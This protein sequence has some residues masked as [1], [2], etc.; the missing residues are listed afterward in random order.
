MDETIVNK[1]NQL[2]RN[3]ITEALL[4]L[5]K[6][7]PLSAVTINELTQSAGVSRMAFYRNFT[8]KEDVLTSRIDDILDQFKKE[9]SEQHFSTFYEAKNIRHCLAY[10]HRHDDFVDDLIIYG[11]SDT[12]LH[13]LTE[14]ALD[15]WL[16]N[17]DD[18]IEYYR[19]VSFTGMLFNCYLNWIQTHN[20]SFD[21]LI[22]QVIC[23]CEQAYV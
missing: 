6:E 11:L 17:R 1:Q 3:S 12:L 8:S 7:K 21:E 9:T 14:Y 20:I 16:P 18:P 22:K 5:I 23:M 19:L 4:K 10:F 15:M 13:D 2:T